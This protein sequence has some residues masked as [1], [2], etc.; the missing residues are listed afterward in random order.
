MTG[1]YDLQLVALS[2][3]VAI[4]AS[5]TALELAGRVSQKQGASS[6]AWL[7]GGAVSMGIGIWSM[8]FIGMLAFKL[9]VA[10]AYDAAATMLSMA[11]AIVVS[12][13][14]SL[15]LTPGC[16]GADRA[17]GSPLTKV[18]PDGAI[19]GTDVTFTLTATNNGPSP[20]TNVTVSDPLPLGL[21]YVSATA[22][23]GS[24]FSLGPNLV[25][26]LGS[27]ARGYP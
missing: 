22:S 11:I 5:Y 3:I 15:T 23:Q 7:A 26:S 2:L 6:W 10:V 16:V 27:L 19:L 24:C 4:M 13:F 1:V 17:T 12:G 20:A 18:G 21:A 25:C 8:H 9:P 14:V